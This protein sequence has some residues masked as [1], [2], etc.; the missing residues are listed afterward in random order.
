MQKTLDILPELKRCHSSFFHSC[1]FGKKLIENQTIVKVPDQEALDV[2]GVVC[3]TVGTK[4]I[5]RLLSVLKLYQIILL[6]GA[7][8]T[9]QE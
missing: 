6:S 1:I 9:Y 7:G 8:R 4:F 2:N 5:K 3:M